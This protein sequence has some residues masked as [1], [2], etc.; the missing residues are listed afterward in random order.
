MNRY[1]IHLAFFILIACFLGGCSS[2]HKS[3]EKKRAQLHLKMGVGYLSKG[4]HPNALNQFILAAQLDAKDPVI[5]HNLGLAY[6][7][8]KRYVRAEEYLR[9]AVELEAG[10]TEARNNLGRS[11]IELSMYKEAIQEL[12]T[13]RRDLTFPY[14]EK[15]LAYLGIAYFKL[16]RFKKSIQFFKEALLIKPTDCTSQ[17]FLGRSYFELKQFS[18]ATRTLDRAITLC[19]GVAFDEPYYYSALG[20]YQMGQTG[21]AIAKLEALIRQLPRGAHVDHAHRLL[22]ILE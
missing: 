20:Y 16:G 19:Q 13:A 9:R 15:T 11:L 22:R 10:Y 12:E 1:F 2:F 17:N 18:R 21:H 7:A 14:V 6:F 3:A 8:R 4:D 5:Q